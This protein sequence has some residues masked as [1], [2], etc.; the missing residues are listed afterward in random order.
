MVE[1]FTFYFYYFTEKHVC[2]QISIIKQIKSS[3][4]KSLRRCLALPICCTLTAPL[5]VL[6]SHDCLRSGP[7]DIGEL[8]VV[9]T[10][11]GQVVNASFVRSHTH[12]YYQV[13]L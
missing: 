13:R 10:P 1:A 5:G 11:N 9:A 2:E 8:I 4:N 7:P 12:N 6:Q 3:V